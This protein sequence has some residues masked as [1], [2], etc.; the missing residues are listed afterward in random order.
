MPHLNALDIATKNVITGA[1]H[2]SLAVI[3]DLMIKHGVGRIVITED[4][5]PIGIVTKRDIVKF[6]SIDDTDRSL[7]EIPVS[8]VMNINLVIIKPNL[9][10]RTTASIMLDNNI[11]SLLIVDKERL[12]GI[13][14][15]TDICRYCSEHCKGVFKVKDFMTRNVIYVKPMHSLFRIM[16][17]MVK[18]NISRVLV[19]SDDNKPLGIV[20][21]T[22]LTFYTSSLRPV[23]HPT[24]EVIPSSL[25][26]TAEDIMT[27]NPITINE[28]ED[29]SKASEIM[30][31]RKISGLPVIDHNERLSGIITKTDIVKAVA[32]FKD[33]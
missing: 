5:K 32:C 15:K 24:F 19:L 27:R 26:M 3:R 29:I 13:I 31:E 14:T 33:A 4:N 10:V 28:D 7:L 21:L 30:V 22:D 11:S 20:T 17:L 12:V 25:I 16:N 1:P 8:E 6:L 9:D 2:E 18:H 23:K